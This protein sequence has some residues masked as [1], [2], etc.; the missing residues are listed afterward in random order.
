MAL[1]GA[2]LARL[3][4]YRDFGQTNVAPRLTSQL[5]PA[6]FSRIGV[7]LARSEIDIIPLQLDQLAGR[8]SVPARQEDG[9]G[10]A[11]RALFSRA[12]SRSMPRA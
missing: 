9:R 12:T 11:G 4:H 6:D 3:R 8:Q 5:Q 2:R 7:Q 1:G 10:T